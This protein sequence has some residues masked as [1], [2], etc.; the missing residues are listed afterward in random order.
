MQRSQQHERKKINN[1]IEG[2][3]RVK[4]KNKNT[5]NLVVEHVLV[6]EPQVERHERHAGKERG[7]GGAAPRVLH[8]ERQQLVERQEGHDAGDG[9]FDVISGDGGDGEE[10]EQPLLPLFLLA[11]AAAGDAQRRAAQA[12][13]VML[14]S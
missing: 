14:A 13:I 4:E 9:D 11:A 1:T 3:A 12:D 10:V 2:R 6:E 5:K 7:D 8:G